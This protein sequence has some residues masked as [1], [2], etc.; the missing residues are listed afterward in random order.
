MSDA[1]PPRPSLVKPALIVGLATGL[2]YFVPLLNIL[3]LCGLGP[4]LAG[5]VAVA[6]GRRLNRGDKTAR[7]LTN[8]EGA[9]LGA[10]TGVLAAA[11][12]GLLLPF[13]LNGMQDMTVQDT[14]VEFYRQQGGMTR[15]DAEA[16]VEHGVAAASSPA[17]R[18]AFTLVLAGLNAALGALG[19]LLGA[20]LLRRR[21]AAP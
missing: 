8:G 10:L 7:P 4:M 6:V 1:T 16:L 9:K 20:P 19:G 11:V 5:G 2:L 18:L 13:L 12:V 21:P 17:V 15:P 14:M 3:N